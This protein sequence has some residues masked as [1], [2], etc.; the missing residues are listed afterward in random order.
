ML[1]KFQMETFSM[2]EGNTQ[3]IQDRTEKFSVLTCKT[4]QLYKCLLN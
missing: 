1:H 3:G 2:S 4:G